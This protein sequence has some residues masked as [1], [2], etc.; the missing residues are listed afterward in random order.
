MT[1]QSGSS[2]QFVDLVVVLK[3]NFVNW[4]NNLEIQD[5]DDWML[6][7]DFNFYRTLENRNREGGNMNDI[8]VFN[9]IISNLGLLEIPLKGRQFTWSNMQDNPLLEQ[10][11]WC[12]TSSHWISAYPN[13]LLLPLAKPLSDH[14]P[15]VVQIDT[16]IP[17]SNL[18]RFE[19][20][21]V[22]QLGFFELVEEIWKTETNMNN[23]VARVSAKLK[24]LRKALK[25]WSKNISQ[26]NKLIQE[27]NTVLAVLDKLEDQRPLFTQESN[28]RKI[29]KAH[30]LKLLQFKKEY[31]RKRYTLRWTKMGDESTSFFHAAA[32]ERYRHN[33]ITSLQTPYDRTVTEH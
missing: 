4:L 10:L 32:T 26:L 7:G 3:E 14:L 15:C 8:F 2:L 28:F 30:I 17:K 18:F 27:C 5:D 21:W 11:D 19:N 33:T 12:F 23:S 29:L 22:E 6:I 20:F 1:N 31:W 9:E 24:L 13:T 25:K 16:A